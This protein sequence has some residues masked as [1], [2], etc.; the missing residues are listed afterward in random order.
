MA[1]FSLGSFVSHQMHI[2]FSETIKGAGL[3]HGFPYY[4]RGWGAW[5]IDSIRNPGQKTGDDA[6]FVY[7]IL[8]PKI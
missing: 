3:M 5:G 8:F 7:E 2:V 6:E 4:S 1:G